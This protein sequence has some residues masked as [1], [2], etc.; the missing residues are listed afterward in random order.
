MKKL[1][2]Q[3]LNADG[4]ILEYFMAIINGHENYITIIN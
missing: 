1:N 4:F 2:I 3:S